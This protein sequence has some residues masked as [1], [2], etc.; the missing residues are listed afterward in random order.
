MLL[1]RG[2]WRLKIDVAIQLANGKMFVKICCVKHML[3]VQSILCAGALSSTPFVDFFYL[4]SGLG[5]RLV[6]FG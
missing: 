4:S 2:A 1:L 5:I 3:C 6:N